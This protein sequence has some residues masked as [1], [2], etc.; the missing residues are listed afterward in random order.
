MSRNR[1]Y[2]SENIPSELLDTSLW[3]KVLV[4]QLDESS[5]T[6]FLTR[7]QAVE[8]YLKNEKTLNEIR[9]ITG[10]TRANVR[11]YTKR[12][13]ETDKNNEIWGFRALIP[14]KKTRSHQRKNFKS[15]SFAGVF[16]Q[17]LDTYPSID[18]IIHDYC[19]KNN[20]INNK[21]LHKKFLDACR[22]VGLTIKD[23]PFNTESN[24]LR[25]LQKYTKTIKNRNFKKQQVYSQHSII[26][27]PFQRV[28]FDGHRIDSVIA[29]TFKTPEG[30]EIVEVLNRIWLLVV[31]DVATRAILGY[32]LCLNKE[33]SANDVLHCIKNSIVPHEPKTLTIPGLKLSSS[34]NF[35]SENIKST[36]WGLWDEFH[37]DNAKANLSNIVRDRLTQVIGCSI[38]AGPV[39]TPERRGIIERFFRTLEENGYHKLSTTTGSH[40][41]DPI[42]RA[43][44]QKAIKY[45][46]SAAHLEEITEVLIAN[47]NG[48]PNEG[49]NNLT[50]LEAIEQRLA[51]GMYIRQIPEE[52]RSEVIFFYMKAERTIQGNKENGQRPHINYEGVKYYNE[53]LSRSFELIGTKLTILVNTEDLRI[54]KAFLPDGSEFGM[55]T[56]FGKWGITPHDLKTRKTINKLRKRK[57][58]HLLQE[59]DPIDVLT[60]H[61]EKEARKNKNSRNT[62]AKLNRYIETHQ[63]TNDVLI[64][65]IEKADFEQKKNNNTLPS[66]KNKPSDVSSRR[67]TK[68]IMY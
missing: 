9:D 30:D 17:L 44:E 53:I 59:D 29:I 2:E 28:Q 49:V 6:V 27:R 36:Q 50:P 62:L 39:R 64:E 32:H 8:L 16:Q 51:R 3:P 12:C 25:T 61:L 23:Y 7:K 45:R 58:I 33:Y 56:A 54:V 15:E 13:L 31:I 18:D 63:S 35:P 11:K 40:P 42:R 38:N 4:D 37:Y 65:P 47:Y 19:K 1:F 41:K 57:M 60:K 26:S 55:L 48:T 24:G 10:I 52:K 22:S 66:N 68:T 43:P 34:G 20:R 67:L 5:K 21:V 46:V 14:F